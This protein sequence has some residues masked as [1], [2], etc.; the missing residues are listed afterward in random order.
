MTHDKSR[1]NVASQLE[2]SH[3]DLF[4][5]ITKPNQFPLIQG[6]SQTACN[7]KNV[8]HDSCTLYRG[9]Y[10]VPTRGDFFTSWRLENLHVT[11]STKHNHT[12]F[13]VRPEDHYMPLQS[14]TLV[15]I[16]CFAIGLPLL[17]IAISSD[18]F[19]NC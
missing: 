13:G 12:S 18:L 3:P 17:G 1:T 7:H 19:R 6:G 14:S 5:Y 2:K 8:C 11:M 10:P 9:Y 16:S 4:P 15:C